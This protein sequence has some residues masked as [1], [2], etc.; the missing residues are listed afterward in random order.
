MSTSRPSMNSKGRA[1]IAG[2]MLALVTVSGRAPATIDEYVTFSGFG[3]LGEVHSDYGNADF[4]GTVSQPRGA[5][6]SRSWSPTPDSDL[7]GQANI[8]LTDS[9]SG[10]VQVLSRDDADGN[11]KPAVEWANLKY[12][13]T[14]D[15]AVRLGRILL[16]TNDRSDIQ[17]VGYALPWVRVPIEITYTA[18]ATH[19][20]GLDLL[21]RIKT[22]AVTQNLEVQWGS[23]TEN[24]P[25]AAF[26]SNR[27]HVAVF[28]DT[29]QYG[30]ASLHLVYQKYLPSG[31]PPARLQ[32][33]GAG[34]TYDP[35]AWFVTGD[36][37]YTQDTFFGDFLAWYVSGGVRL[38]RFTPYA[39]YSTTHAPSVGTSG[40]TSLG[41][42]HTVGAG[43]RWDFAKNLDFKLQLEQVTIDTLDDPA[44]FANLQPGA[45][46]GDK[47]HVLS[48]SLDFVF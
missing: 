46:V 13:F 40:L 44:A 35:G 31:F 24:L 7:G 4:I 45:R 33:V 10:V 19:S 27:V 16:P 21:Y 30:D 9:L 48:L 36:S 5:G 34:F 18:S 8:T 25:G 37:N 42:E 41:N 17:N 6:Y 26:T 47:V 29:L 3:T 1:V 15:L 39:L 22:G 11:F 12:E 20:D 14:P 43:L 38:G 23:A 28:S 2:S 32:L